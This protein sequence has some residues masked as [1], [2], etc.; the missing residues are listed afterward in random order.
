[1]KY[2]KVEMKAL[3]DTQLKPDMKQ[4]AW[5]YVNLNVEPCRPHGTILTLIC[6]GSIEN[7]R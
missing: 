3:F 6:Y 4:E 1:M 7:K 5:N 2:A